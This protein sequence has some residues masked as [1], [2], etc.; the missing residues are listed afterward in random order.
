MDAYVTG[1]KRLVQTC[2]YRTLADEMIGDEVLEKCYST[3]LRLLREQTLTLD[4]VLRT[5]RRAEALDH[6]AQQI[7]DAKNSENQKAVNS[8]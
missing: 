2:G 8:A 3:H 1:L 6:Q 5:T 7:E 4:E